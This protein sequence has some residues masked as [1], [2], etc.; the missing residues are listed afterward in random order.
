LIGKSNIEKIG[1]R[2][3]LGHYEYVV[4]PFGLPIVVMTLHMFN[5]KYLV[6]IACHA[7]A[8]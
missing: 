1:F 2:A 3:R 5:S 7:I 4:M 6:H 8:M